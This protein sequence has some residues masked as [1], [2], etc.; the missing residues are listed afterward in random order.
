MDI[1]EIIKNLNNPEFNI[2]LTMLLLEIHS[3]NNINNFHLKEILKLQLELK[4]LQIG[5]T[6]Q[7]AESNVEKKIDTLNKK[8][9]EWAKEDLIHFLNSFPNND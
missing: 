6:G 1:N 3:Q 4:E 2:D 8:F 9:S 7:E 5:N